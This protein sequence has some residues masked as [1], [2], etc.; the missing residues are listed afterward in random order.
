MA[1]VV[2]AEAARQAKRPVRWQV[3]GA[4]TGLPFSHR[5][6]TARGRWILFGLPPLEVEKS[7]ARRKLASGD[8]ES[9]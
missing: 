2:Q 6:F 4:R 1:V 9:A 3:P 7:V 8:K 5:G